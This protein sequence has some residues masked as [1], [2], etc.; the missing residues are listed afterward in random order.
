MPLADRRIRGHVSGEASIADLHRDAK[1]HARARVRPAEDRARRA[2]RAASVVLDARAG[3][4]EAK[5]RLEQTD[6]YAD[7]RAT[8]DLAWGAALAPSRRPERE[9]SRRTSTRRPSAPPRSCRSCSPRSTS[10]TGASTR[11]RPS[12]IGPGLEDAALQGKVVFH[13]GTVQ[14]AAFGE[15]LKDARATVTFQPGGVIAIDDVFMR[16]TDGELTREGGREDA[17]P[18]ARVGQRQPAHPGSQGARRLVARAAHRRRLRR[19]RRSRRPRATTASSYASQVDVPTMKVTLPQ[20]M[21]SGVQELEEK[22]TIRVGTFRNAKTFVRL[23]L[24]K[25]DL[26]AGRRAGAEPRDGHRRRHP[27]RG[28]HGHAGQPGEGGARRNARTS[29]SPR[30]RRSRARSRSRRARSTCRA[31]GSRSRRA[32]SRSSPRTRRIRPSSRPQRG[33]PTTA[34][35]SS[36]TSSDR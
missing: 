13:D 5:A 9:A 31:S 34:P 1:V 3:K 2:T 20:K 35:R 36:R 28:H 6:G 8:T 17:R 4:L 27:P 14:L 29:A 23:P 15:E 18:R 10:S 32:P 21:K 33:P 24:D 25:E 12:K 30:P 26:D 7:V 22:E 16:A 11:T 19:R